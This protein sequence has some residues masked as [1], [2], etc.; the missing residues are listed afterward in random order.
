M[1]Q[2]WLSVVVPAYNE[3]KV[4][5]GTVMALRD[6]LESDGRPYEVVIVDNASTD[7]TPAV[8]EPL[9]DGTKI[10]LLRNEVNRGKVFSVRRGMLETSGALRLMCDADCESS[11]AS[12]PKMVSMIERGAADV[13]A[14]SGEAG[15]ADVG[16]TQ[17]IPRR[18]ASWNFIRLC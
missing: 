7:S 17:P 1:G 12:I 5:A 15:G 2:P 3:E 4:I 14:G 9:L 10:R 16:K 6:M 13:V 18:I 8:L 11:L